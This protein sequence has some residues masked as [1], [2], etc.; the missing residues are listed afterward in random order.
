MSQSNQTIIFAPNSPIAYISIGT[1]QPTPQLIISSLQSIICAQSNQAVIFSSNSPI[2]YLCIPQLQAPSCTQI[3][4][5]YLAIVP[6]QDIEVRAEDIMDLRNCLITILEAMLPH[7]VEV[8]QITQ[9]IY[10][11]QQLDLKSGDVLKAEYRNAISNAIEQ[12]LNILSSLNIIK[13]AN[14]E[15]TI[16]ESASSS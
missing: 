12:I 6:T 5:Q 15:I 10:Q 3:A 8:G 7:V 1:P 4:Q 16:T 9:L 11:L 13:I 14:D 2:A